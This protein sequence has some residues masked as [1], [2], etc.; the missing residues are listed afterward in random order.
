MPHQKPPPINLNPITSTL[1]FHH[2]EIVHKSIIKYTLGGAVGQALYHA[3]EGFVVL[4]EVVFGR[5]LEIGYQ[6]WLITEALGRA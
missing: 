2:F 6:V 4:F 5:V 3:E 1:V